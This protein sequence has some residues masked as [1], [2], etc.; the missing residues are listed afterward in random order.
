MREKYRC[1][2][3]DA[4]NFDEFNETVLDFTISSA[5]EDGL[6]GY[7]FTILV[8][9]EYRSRGIG[10]WAMGEMERVLH[11]AGLREVEFFV[12]R[13]NPRGQKFY[14]DQGY[15]IVEELDPGFRMG[16]SL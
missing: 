13:K 7:L 16:K 14:R 9:P 2:K 15:R 1:T 3:I 11:E 6:Q 12:S 4:A 10:A 5:R 8:F